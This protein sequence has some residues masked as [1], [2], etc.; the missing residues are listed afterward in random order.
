MNKNP[1]R[2]LDSKEKQDQEVV[3]GAPNII[4][5][6]DE[7]SRFFEELVS[8]LDKLKIDYKINRFLVRGLDYYNHTAFEYIT[9]DKKSQN[10]VL[11]G[12]RY[13]GLIKNLGGKIIWCWMG[14]RNRKNPNAT[15]KFEGPSLKK[16]VY[17]QLIRN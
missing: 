9:N 14:S 16:S 8:S 5:Y 2:I 6:L 1:L 11:A 12:G 17:S 15:K 4:D 13:N 7:E 3:Q 10:T